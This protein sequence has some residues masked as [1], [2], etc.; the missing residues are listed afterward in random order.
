MARSVSKSPRVAEQCDVNIHS[1]VCEEGRTQLMVM[2][3]NAIRNGQDYELVAGVSE[4]ETSAAEYSQCRGN[5]CT[6]N[7]SWL[8]RHPIGVVELGGVSSSVILVT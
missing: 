4:F 7:L 1:L 5:H 8:K 6:L 3:E 2:N